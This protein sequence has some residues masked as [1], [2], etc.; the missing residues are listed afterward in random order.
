MTSDLLQT[1]AKRCRQS[2]SR[3]F[4]IHF[5]NPPTN[6]Y[7][8]IVN[9]NDTIDFV[10]IDEPESCPYLDGKTA[11]M[12]L[13]IALEKITPEQTDLRLANG[14]RRS[15]EFIYQTKCPSCNACQPIRLDC[16]EFAFSRNQRRTINKGDRKFHQ[17]TGSLESD[18]QR[19]DLFNK[20]RQIRGLAKSTN[21]IDADDYEYGFVR[22]CFDSF[23]ITYWQNARLVCLAVCDRGKSSMS[24]VYTFFDP[25]LKSDSLG[26][27]SILKQIQFCQ[28]NHFQY[29]YLGYY[30]AD[31][32]H[33]N[34]K[35]RFTPNE[36][37]I[38]NKWIRFE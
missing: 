12:P 7:R 22:S 1:A 18:Q 8:I 14:N 27:Y 36:R 10:I 29:L 9:P 17:R 25:D 20:H 3:T 5:D 4:S 34:Y 16:N 11:R 21:G 26:T 31:S 33:M 6:Q 35:S 23:E 30:I 24:A 2:L 32:S 15:G 28:T 37:L 13:R 38:D 19:T